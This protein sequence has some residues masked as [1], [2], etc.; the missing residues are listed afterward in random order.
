MV[1]YY[2]ESVEEFKIVRGDDEQVEFIAYTDRSKASRLNITG[3]ALTFTLRRRPDT[4]VIAIQLTTGGGTIVVTNPT[5][6]EYYL[7]LNGIHTT[8]DPGLYVYDIVLLLAGDLSTLRVD[9]VDFKWGV[10]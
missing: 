10:T 4:P 5:Q 7:D 6:G 2:T 3:G 1:E 9:G 8:I